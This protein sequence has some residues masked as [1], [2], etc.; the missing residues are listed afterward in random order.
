MAE[1]LQKNVV[2][3]SSTLSTFLSE[4]F[5]WLGDALGLGNLKNVFDL[6]PE[7]SELEEKV[8]SMEEKL[9]AGT[10]FPDRH[11]G[12]EVAAYRTRIVKIVEKLKT[13]SAAAIRAGFLVKAIDVLYKVTSIGFAQNT[14]RAEPV[15]INLYST[16]GKGKSTLTQSLAHEILASPGILTKEQRELYARQRENYIYCID[17]TQNYPD[18][19]YSQFVT[20]LDDWAI[21]KDSL[22]ADMESGL[23]ALIR[24]VNGMPYNVESAHLELKGKIFANNILMIATTNNRRIDPESFPGFTDVN[25]L[26]RRLHMSYCL[27]YKEEYC[28]NPKAKYADR[29]LRDDL[30]DQFVIN[31]DGERVPS[32]SYDVWEFVP[33]NMA[34]GD[35][36]YLPNG[37]KAP[38]L[39]YDQVIE[40]AVARVKAS[41][42]FN[43]KH[44]AT[45]ESR[46]AE[47]LRLAALAD[48]LEP[49]SGKPPK[50]DY[51]MTSPFWEKNHK[52]KA[53][54]VKHPWVRDAYIQHVQKAYPKEVR[55]HLEN[56]PLFAEYVVKLSSAYA[57]KNT[58]AAKLLGGT[59]IDWFKYD[60]AR[61]K[62]PA[63]SIVDC[64]ENLTLTLP[65]RR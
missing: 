32:I 15:C 55:E 41:R 20:I 35:V 26:I 6:H 21:R 14:V 65:G 61:T 47:K 43:A 54:V 56:E 23:V 50:T 44:K 38:N 64:I 46:V 57:P 12:M 42:D 51:V 45:I 7:L 1:K 63:L 4:L 13:G 28:K 22:N 30:A 52:V 2:F 25:A 53:Y 48:A 18:G 39:T 5:S 8:R 59:F 36:Q 33:W 9:R 29:V 19:Y 40:E 17:A 27:T 10:I 11:M 58:E 3:C 31:E 16:P 34:R 60:L 49:Q 37:D 24:W 62:N